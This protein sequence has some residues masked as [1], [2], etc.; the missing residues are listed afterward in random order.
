MHDKTHY[1]INYQEK[2][3]ICDLHFESYNSY[4]PTCKKDLCFYCKSKHKEHNIIYYNKM[5]S[6]I[7]KEKKN[8]NN[9]Y[10]KKERLKNDINP[11]R[12]TRI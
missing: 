12:F 3:F 2:Y 4:C 9:F 7:S 10:E 1:I 11:K 5:I 8:I 6:D